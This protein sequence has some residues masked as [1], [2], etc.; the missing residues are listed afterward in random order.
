MI[1]VKLVEICVLR[2]LLSF[3]RLDRLD[4]RMVALLQGI[5]QVG[6]GFIWR[7]NKLTLSLQRFIK[8]AD[9]VL[10]VAAE[11]NR[12]RPWHIGASH[13]EWLVVCVNIV[14]QHLVR[15]AIGLVIC[16]V[17]S[18]VVIIHFGLEVRWVVFAARPIVVAKVALEILASW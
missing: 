17:C 4:T 6:P 7:V 16:K 5:L 1:R 15:L 8:H 2:I 11:F 13:I 10:S 14:A 9:A 3:I 12:V 18:I